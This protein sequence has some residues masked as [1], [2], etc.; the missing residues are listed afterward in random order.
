MQELQ[1]RDTIDKLMS[2]RVIL[3][4]VGFDNNY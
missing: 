2:M 1:E 4:I 3:K